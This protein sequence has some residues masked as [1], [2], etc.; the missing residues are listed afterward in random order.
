MSS[1]EQS[2]VTRVVEWKGEY[3]V[4]IPDEVMDE[5][6]VVAGDLLEVTLAKVEHGPVK[7][8]VFVQAANR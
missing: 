1:T 3:A 4:S 7:A 8:R 5:M 2:F 6:G